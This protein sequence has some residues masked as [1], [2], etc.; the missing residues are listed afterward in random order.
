MYQPEIALRVMSTA[1]IFAIVL[2]WMK[3]KTIH[4]I[5]LNFGDYLCEAFKNKNERKT[6]R[7]DVSMTS[8]S[9]EKMKY[10]IYILEDGKVTVKVVDGPNAVVVL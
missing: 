9:S 10:E 6:K 1:K 8:F 7:F 5:T 3:V 4:S 2:T